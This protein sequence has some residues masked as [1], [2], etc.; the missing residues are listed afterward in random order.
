[1][2]PDVRPSQTD[3]QHSHHVQ[4]YNGINYKYN[5]FGVQYK[6]HQNTS[7]VN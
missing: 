2:N 6:M 1:M 7:K 3:Y 4:H 5:Q